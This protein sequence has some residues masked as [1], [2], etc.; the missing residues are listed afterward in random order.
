MRCFVLPSTSVWDCFRVLTLFLI[1]MKSSYEQEDRHQNSCDNFKIFSCSC[2]CATHFDYETWR[3]RAEVISVKLPSIKFSFHK[4]R[5]KKII[6]T[7][8]APTQRMNE[9]GNVN[10]SHASSSSSNNSISHVTDGVP[11][12]FCFGRLI[13][14]M[15]F[16]WVFQRRS[17]PNFF[18]QS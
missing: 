15:E 8:T 12:C 13:C 7:F 18:L 10:L 1:E 3:I 6:K 2:W 5:L 17:C 11:K 4:P 14:L 9:N 16:D